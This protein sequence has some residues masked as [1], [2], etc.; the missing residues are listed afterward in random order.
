MYF[1]FN[2]N[3]AGEKEVWSIIGRQ[4][5][6]TTTTLQNFGFLSSEKKPILHKCSRENY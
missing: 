1:F 5:W 3:L 6:K 4:H 2:G